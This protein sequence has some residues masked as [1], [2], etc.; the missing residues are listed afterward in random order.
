MK[1]L[2]SLLGLLGLLALAGCQSAHDS[3]VE[4]LVARFFLETRLGEAGVP[5][6]LPVSGVR[7]VVNAKPVLVEYDVANVEVAKVDLGWCLL[8]HF[9]PAAARDFYRMSVAAQGRRLFLTLNGNA[10]GAR[11]LDQVMPD[12]TLLIFIEVPN[13]DLPPLADRLSRTSAGLIEKRK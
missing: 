9:T 11:R 12:G 1:K 10:I 4:P 8:F 3:T 5:V 7:A 6:Q 13:E 2:L